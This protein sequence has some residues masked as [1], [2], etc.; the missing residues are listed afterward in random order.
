[1]KKII[2]ELNIENREDEEDAIITINAMEYKLAL[3]EI[4]ELL[5]RCR[6]YGIPEDTNAQEL[7]EKIETEIWQIINDRDIKV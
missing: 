1:M 3:Q 5:R 2:I 4:T 7:V 6:K